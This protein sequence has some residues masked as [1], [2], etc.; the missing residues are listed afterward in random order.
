[1]A[2]T[3]VPE[4]VRKE[5]NSVRKRNNGLE[6][7]P[8]S[9]FCTEKFKK[10]CEIFII[11]TSLNRAEKQFKVHKFQIVPNSPNLQFK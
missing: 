2:K 5:P 1:M 3:R 11:T 7:N 8:K 10:F 9:S 6:I 4:K